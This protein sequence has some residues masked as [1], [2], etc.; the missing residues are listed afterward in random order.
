MLHNIFRVMQLPP[1]AWL[2][3]SLHNGSITWMRIGPSGIENAR[4]LRF[5]GPG[6]FVHHLILTMISTN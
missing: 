4:R 1:E 2:R 5:H 6:E 3:M